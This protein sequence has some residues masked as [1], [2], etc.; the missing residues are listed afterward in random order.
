M[1]KRRR[2]LKNVAGITASAFLPFQGLAQ[3]ATAVDKPDGP[4]NEDYWEIVKQQFSIP[5]SMIMANSANLCPAPRFVDDRVRWFQ[6]NLSSDVSFQNRARYGE[7][8]KMALD[9]LGDY[10]G[11]APKEIGITRNTSESNNIV[12]N[13]LSLKKGDEVVIWD[14][15]HPTNNMAWKNRARRHGFKV[16]SVSVPPHPKTKQE[17]IDSFLQATT[18]KTRIWAF[19]HLSNSSGILLP[20]REMCE[21]ASGRGILTLVDGAQVFGALALDLHELG[22]DFYTASTHKWLMGPMENGILY[23]KESNIEGLWPDSIAP[24][25]T[26]EKES[27]DEKFCS[28]GQ[29]NNPTTAALP[30]ILEFHNQIGKDTIEARIRSLHTRLRE[31]LGAEI[32]AIEFVNP[33]EPS[34]SGGVTIFRVP[35]YDYR[36]VFDRLYTEFGVASAPMDG[37]RFSPTIM[38]TLDDM[39]RLVEATRAIVA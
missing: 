33:M 31:R 35:G 30:D 25:W 16:I 10:V 14:Q 27:V 32:P 28:L 9:M 15:N 2:F 12:V 19:S 23:V 17:L 29:R 20:A 7:L 11:A 36:A 18:P 3:S 24:G 26:M 21:I 37:N 38:N 1:R 5:D 4:V 6:E 39:D 8:R 34:L 13:G 22:C